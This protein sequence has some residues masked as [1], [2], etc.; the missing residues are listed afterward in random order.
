M[1]REY[2]IRKSSPSWKIS[3]WLRFVR[4]AC[5]TF[6]RESRRSFGR[7][8]GRGSLC[9]AGRMVTNPFID[10]SNSVGRDKSAALRRLFA[11]CDFE[12]HL[13]K[14][15]PNKETVLLVTHEVSRSDSTI[16]VQ[17]IAAALRQ[18][19]NVIVLTL[20]GGTLRTGFIAA[21]HL[22][23]G[24][25]SE[26]QRS[27]RFMI[28][29]L[30]EIAS[31][32]PVKF[33]IVSSI[34]S[35]VTLSAFWENDIAIVH[36]IHELAGETRPKGQ[37]RTSALFSGERIFAS[38]LV[39]DAAAAETPDETCKPGLIFPDSFW[40]PHESVVSVTADLTERKQIHSNLLPPAGWPRDQPGFKSFIERLDT[41]AR[42]CASK[43]EQEKIDRLVIS[44]SNLFDFDFF[45]SPLS[46]V[47]GDDPVKSYVSAFS[48]GIKP[49]KAMPGFHPATYQEH[50]DV[51]G[52]DPLAH[53][54]DSGLPSGP[55]NFEVIRP[56]QTFHPSKSLKVGL[57]LH[58]YYDEMI[59][60]IVDR[61]RRVRHP[62]DLLVSVTN[63][64]AGDVA[65]ACLRNYSQGS[66][67][68]RV[69]D[70][71]GRDLG[72]LLSGFGETIL[73]RYDVVGHIHTKKS[74]GI[75]SSESY[76][77]HW[78]KFLY[79]NLLADQYTMA[80]TILQRMA[81]D[82]SI[83]LVFA[84]DPYIL[85]WTGNLPYALC[86]AARMR[87]ARAALPKTTFNFPA[88]TMFWARTMAL[89]PLFE[90]GLSW[91]DY[92]AE[93]LPC[94]GSLLHAIERIL[95][96]AVE[97]AGFRNVVTHVPRITR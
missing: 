56:G 90:L 86:L 32:T 9:T 61:I 5:I 84:D 6:A 58:L 78:V 63:Q 76:V 47:K 57:H 28:R 24:P 16:L 18:Q 92:P 13:L 19:Y 35:S 29:L 62:M 34:Y 53:Y 49:R 27:P 50:N 42:Q 73:D 74:V 94:D 20:Q 59:S 67:D 91:D 89:A 68:I 23:L 14:F 71:C 60:D 55:W 33:A 26:E 79:A 12:R 65:Q 45:G 80:D 40:G 66:V 81:A 44:K 41:V 43:K 31:R 36:L 88:G 11:Q 87:I 72:P 25:L 46:E 64:A 95:P 52:R 3:W 15:E 77:Q 93:P 97:K 8:P 4:D 82:D 75:Y 1:K 22:V 70:N 83:G 69:F 51:D 37:F 48:S 7:L 10:T 17:R 54:I 38:K 85:G 39:H 2:Q 96:T 30:A 21:G